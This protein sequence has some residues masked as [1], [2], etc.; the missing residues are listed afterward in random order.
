MPEKHSVLS[1]AHTRR[2]D[3]VNSVNSGEDLT[4]NFTK[5]KPVSGKRIA[6]ILLVL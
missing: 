2:P 5:P 6:Y 4:M 1:F 3:S